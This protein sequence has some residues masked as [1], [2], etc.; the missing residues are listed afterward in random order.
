MSL[1]VD[2]QPYEVGPKIDD[3]EDSQL[4]TLHHEI[5]DRA[6]ELKVKDGVKQSGS[7]SSSSSS[8]SS[9]VMDRYKCSPCVTAISLLPVT[10]LTYSGT[11]LGVR[12]IGMSSHT[13]LLI[14]GKGFNEPTKV[15]GIVPDNYTLCHTTYNNATALATQYGSVNLASRLQKR[16]ALATCSAKLNTLSYFGWYPNDITLGEF[17]GQ[18]FLVGPTMLT[19]TSASSGSYNQNTPLPFTVDQ[20]FSSAD[21]TSVYDKISSAFKPKYRIPEGYTPWLEWFAADEAHG[22]LVPL[23]TLIPLG[24][25]YKDIKLVDIYRA[26][27]MS[28]KHPTIE[29]AED[30]WF[31]AGQDKEDEWIDRTSETQNLS[32]SVYSS[33][34]TITN[35]G[36][37]T[38]A[39]MYG[40]ATNGTSGATSFHTTDG[41]TIYQ[42]IT[43]HPVT[44][45]VDEFTVYD[46]I[47][48][49]TDNVIDL[50]VYS[51]PNT[52]VIGSMGRYTQYHMSS[53]MA[54]SV[55]VKVSIP[56]HWQQSDI[57]AAEYNGSTITLNISEYDV[58]N[59]SSLT[60][61]TAGPSTSSSNALTFAITGA[62]SYTSTLSNS[63]TYNSW[64]CASTTFNPSTLNKVDTTKFA[65]A[66]IKA[67]VSYTAAE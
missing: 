59:A 18:T 60:L 65:Y 31:C 51:V 1:P 12:S 41:A 42:L 17:M 3:V 26:N 67:T 53:D 58:E 35:L 55:F 16:C 30:W 2:I 6:P 49:T 24:G 61:L 29:G 9:N 11:Y 28:I 27:G 25:S 63:P 14:N 45:T 4:I 39:Q 7:G 37:T 66:H 43:L 33:S 22:T 13:S 48:P 36:N 10:N 54:C 47:F 34:S 44:D 19:S 5:N 56:D 52:T 38:Y 57:T 40:T 64:N 23:K 50:L 46:E 8:S 20:L 32:N 21:I 62:G 15:C